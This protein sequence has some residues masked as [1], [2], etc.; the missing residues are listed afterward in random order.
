MPDS[1]L[2]DKITRW[3]N[4]TATTTPRLGEFPHLSDEHAE[5]L[6][7]VQLIEALAV[8][9]DLHTSRLRTATERR[10]EAQER[11][12]DLAAR[13]TNGLLSHFGKKSQE[14]RQFG[15]GPLVPRARR[16]KGEAEPPAVPPA[17]AEGEA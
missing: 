17:A 16:K 10:R 4:L 15:I 3:K 5:L 2:A 9:E 6:A 8:D 13:I 14:L 1:S 12:V 11:C 7:A